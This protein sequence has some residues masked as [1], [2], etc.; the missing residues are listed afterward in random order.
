MTRKPN[1]LCTNKTKQQQTRPT[2]SEPSE[3]TNPSAPLPQ[4]DALVAYEKLKQGKNCAGKESGYE[5]KSEM[6]LKVECNVVSSWETLEMDMS[7][8]Q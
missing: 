3:S 7:R 6:N 4:G 5:M 8:P 1:E 2:A